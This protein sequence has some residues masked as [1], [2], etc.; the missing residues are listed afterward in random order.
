[1]KNSW[2]GFLLAWQFFSAVPIKKQLDMNSKSVTWMY[3]FLPIVGLLIGAIISSGVLI[4]SR[5][6]E[7]SELLLAILIV[8]GL[9]VLTGGLHLDGWIDMSDAFFSYGEKE[10][11]L[12]ILDDPRTGAF[13]VISVFCLLV[14]KIGVIYEM[15]LH[16]QLAIVPFLIFIPFIARM[17]MLLYFVTMQPAKEKGLAAYFKGI[18]IQNKLA[19]LIGVQ[20]I[21]AFVCWFYIGV[22]SLFILVVVMLFAVFI[23][24]N[25]SKKHFG[26]VTGDLLGALGEGL[27]VVLWLTIL[28]C[29]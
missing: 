25:W 11:R 20:S 15:L 27:E 9:I 13:G 10:K 26:G 29:I 23:Y 3:G 22:F 2:S 5:Y 6:S 18:V 1:M 14:L 4:L 17:G 16:G 19:V 12:E 21:L 28:L 7:I 8:I 24:R